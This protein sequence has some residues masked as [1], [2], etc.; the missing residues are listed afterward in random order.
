M[1]NKSPLEKRALI[2]GITGQDGS[3]LS[4][5]LIKK[6]YEVYGL[7]RRK[8]LEDQSVK[9][10]ND[11][12]IIP[13]DI[14]NYSSVFSA[15]GK[16]IPDEI[17]HLAA[18]SDVGYSFEDRFQTLSTNIDGT[19]NVLEAMKFLVPKSKLYFAGSSEMFGKAQEIPQTEK[20]PF[21][22]RSPYGIS[23]CAG[24]YL[25]QNHREAHDL[26]ICNGIL[27]N[28]EGPRRGKEF[29]T[30]KVSD[31]V[32]KIILGS[33]DCLEVGNID[34]KRDWG[35]AGDYVKAMWLM[36]QK[37]KPEDYVIGTGETHSVR[38]FIEEAFKVIEMPIKWE[39]NGLEEVGKHNNA[40]VVR[41]NPKFYR[42]AEV[43]FL[44]ADP[45]KA[46]EEL[47]WKAKTTFKE[48]VKMM[49]KSD[50]RKLKNSP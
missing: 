2:T 24:F 32:A 20:T 49:V 47:G 48:L 50:I 43:D 9:R 6:G 7:E 18:Q 16:V 26:F 45:S 37:D 34:S 33:Q 5:F 44:L 3:Y 27:F 19:L 13:G 31:L 40:T 15:V 25:C 36:L 28:H 29:V 22:P 8:A 10:K 35:Y 1:K 39:G 17:Y 41:I 42:P 4:E 23:K 30:R 14:T 38:E 11:A 46:K 21:H 12:I